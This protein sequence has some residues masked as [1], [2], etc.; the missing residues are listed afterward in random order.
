MLTVADP[1]VLEAVEQAESQNLLPRKVIDGARTIYSS[2]VLGLPKD[3]L[4][5]Q[6]A[7]CDFGEARIGEWHKGL[8]QPELYRAPE[9]LFEM[10][11]DSSIDIWSVGTL[12]STGQFDLC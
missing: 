4:W 5:G 2:H 3:S 12:V 9:V 8:V 11:W 1:S 6:P 10:D 7:L